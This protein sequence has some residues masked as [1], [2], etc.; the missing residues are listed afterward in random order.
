MVGNKLRA[1]INQLEPGNNLDVLQLKNGSRKC[2][3]YKQCN[4][5]QL[6]KERDYEFCKHMD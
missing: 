3:T 1:D 2:V 5:I 4:A 6:L